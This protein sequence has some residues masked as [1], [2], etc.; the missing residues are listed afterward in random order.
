[1][2]KTRD[3]LGRET[4]RKLTSTSK[5]ESYTAAGNSGSTPNTSLGFDGDDNATKSNTPVGS[6][7][8]LGCTD[9]GSPDAADKRCDEPNG[10]YDGVPSTV[11]GSQWLP[12]RATN[13]QGGRTNMTYEATGNPTGVQQTTNGGLQTSQLSFEYEPTAS[14][15]NAKPGQLKAVRDGLNNPT[16]YGYDAK[17]NVSTVTPPAPLGQTTME[18][19]QTINRLARVKD[20]NGNWRLLT[21]DNLDRLTKIEFTGADQVL[22]STEPY[23]AYAYDRDGNQTAE[24]SRR[25]GATTAETRS[26]TYDALNRVT[27][28]ALPGGASN[29]MSYDR[30]GNLTSLTDAGGKVEYAYDA[31][32][33]VRAVFEPGTTKPTKFEHNVD[34]LRTKTS[35]PTASAATGAITPRSG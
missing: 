20:A 13:P 31:T 26:M 30:V 11:Q 6:G 3:P 2:T 15:V 16:T 32:N 4:T 19:A 23:V 28:E 10:T 18:Y 14:A 35:Y 1:M 12:G 33:Q 7:G 9:Y 24:E 29:T 27:Y 8:I 17:G 21:Y 25:P 5:V 34:G 22:G